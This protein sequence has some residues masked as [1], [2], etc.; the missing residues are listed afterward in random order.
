MIKAKRLSSFEKAR[1][2]HMQVSELC[3]RI[4]TLLEQ[5]ADLLKNL[6]E[7]QHRKLLTE[8]GFFFAEGGAKLLEAGSYH[9]LA[10]NWKPKLKLVAK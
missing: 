7:E 1:L 5:E 4:G 6:D 8:S 3:D 10:E 9:T 2:I